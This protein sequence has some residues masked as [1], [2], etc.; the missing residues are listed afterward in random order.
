MPPR[1]QGEVRK[2]LLLPDEI[3]VN[4]YN[5]IALMGLREGAPG[6]SDLP[7]DLFFPISRFIL[8]HVDKNIRLASPLKEN[9]GS[10][11]ASS[12]PQQ[13]CCQYCCIFNFSTIGCRF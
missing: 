12:T 2:L 1:P 9:P 7:V 8:D 6:A 3:E 10:S 5:T 4:D 11:A 13:S